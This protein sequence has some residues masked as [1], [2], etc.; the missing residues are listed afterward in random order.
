[1][2]GF[3]AIL[4]SGK[5]KAEFTDSIREK[6]G[7]GGRVVVRVSVK[8]DARLETDTDTGTAA[9]VFGGIWGRSAE[10]CKSGFSGAA[11]PTQKIKIGT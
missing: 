4:K 11:K 1:M 9:R 7:K 5:W 10:F 6:V 2:S 3:F 8:C